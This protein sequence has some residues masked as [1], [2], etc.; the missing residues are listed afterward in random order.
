MRKGSFDASLKRAEK[1]VAS[2]GAGKAGTS[3][4]EGSAGGAGRALAIAARSGVDDMPSGV[5]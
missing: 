1:V 4:G 5:N 3:G 2:G